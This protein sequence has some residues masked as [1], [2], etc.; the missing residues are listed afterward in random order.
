MAASVGW[1]LGPLNPPEEFPEIVGKA[2]LWLNRQSCKVYR[3]L[4]ERFGGLE[5]CGLEAITW[6]KGQG[7]AHRILFVDGDNAVIRIIQVDWD[8]VRV[9]TMCL[10]VE[11]CDLDNP[12]CQ[13][14]YL[15]F[16]LEG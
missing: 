14:V 6:V 7:W 3:R 15:D 1:R 9:T 16:E 11:W 8:L 13:G 10:A 2:D 4:V 5:A 12:G